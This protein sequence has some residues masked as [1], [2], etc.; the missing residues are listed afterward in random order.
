L[1]LLL[2]HCAYGRGGGIRHQ[3]NGSSTVQVSKHGGV[4]QT[5]HALLEDLAEFWCLVD[6]L[7]AFGTTAG[8]E[9]V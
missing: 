6:E 4:Q 8:E 1:S 5:G 3:G 7:R 9:E 2:Q